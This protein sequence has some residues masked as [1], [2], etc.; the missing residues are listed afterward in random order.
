MSVHS[1]ASKVVFSLEAPKISD[2]LQTVIDNKV[3]GVALTCIQ[4][5]VH[6]FL[7]TFSCFY[8]SYNQIY[9]TKE[10]HS[11]I[12]H[13]S[14]G[15]VLKDLTA[16]KVASVKGIGLE[17]IALNGYR[18]IFTGSKHSVIL[19]GKAYNT[20]HI[21]VEDQKGH[22]KQFVITE[23]ETTG[24]TKQTVVDTNKVFCFSE[25]TGEGFVYVTEEAIPSLDPEYLSLGIMSVPLPP[26]V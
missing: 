4:E 26:R 5:L 17:Y 3:S 25:F 24:S 11:R 18:V 22:P 20:D 13:F 23:H 15:T 7:T 21:I 16:E 1:A 14:D 2:Y 12:R 8:P 6:W 10:E 9:Q 19:F